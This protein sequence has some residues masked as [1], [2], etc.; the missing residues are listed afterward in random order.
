MPIAYGIHSERALECP[1]TQRPFSGAGA[2]AESRTPPVQR[3]AAIYIRAQRIESSCLLG[4]RVSIG[5]AQ[6]VAVTRLARTTAACDRLLQE[7]VS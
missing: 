5:R 2:P 7:R 1:G 4:N 3:S 6:V